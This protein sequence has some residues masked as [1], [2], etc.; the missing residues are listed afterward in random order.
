MS[1][2]SPAAND[3]VTKQ[4]EALQRERSIYC[5]RV[6]MLAEIPGR[7]DEVQGYLRLIDNINAACLRLARS[8]AEAPRTFGQQ[9]LAA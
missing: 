2:N 5:A 4:L 8:M 1:W 3:V 9:A 7:R 6:S